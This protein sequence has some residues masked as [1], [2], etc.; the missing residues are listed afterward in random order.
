[1]TKSWYVDTYD[2]NSN[3]HWRVKKLLFHKKTKF[4]DIKIFDLYQCG[5]SLVIDG[6]PQSSVEEEWIYHEVLIHP[7]LILYGKKKNLEILVLGAGE[8]A[9][10]REILKHKNIKSINTVDI[11]RE[12]VDIFKKFFPEMHQGFFDHPKVNLIFDS[13]ENFLAKSNKKYDV[14][15]LDISDLGYYN[16][17]S[18]VKKSETHFYNL[19]RKNLDQ[20][21]VLAMHST[22]FSE[23]NYAGHIRLKKIL[24]KVFKKVYSCRVYLSFF[25]VYWGFL[26]ASPYHNNKFNPLAVSEKNLKKRFKETG[27]EGKLKYLSPEMFKAIFTLPPFLKKLS[28]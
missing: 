9:T 13:A 8:G 18:R 16:L 22:N 24:E 28:K 27:L 3:I 15:Y 20:N 21:G 4:Q 12:A 14:I 5:K 23:V 11:D 25:G 19:I 17:S 10:L 6:I 7:A 2:P 1:M 26:V